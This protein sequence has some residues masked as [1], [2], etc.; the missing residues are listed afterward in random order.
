MALA[1]AGQKDG[2]FRSILNTA[3]FFALADRDPLVPFEW[4]RQNRLSFLSIPGVKSG[5]YE[6][7][8]TF[9]QKE[10]SQLIGYTDNQLAMIAVLREKLQVLEGK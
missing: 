4:M 9:L 1:M 2:E 8:G 10:T 6:M 3:F 7:L 5:I